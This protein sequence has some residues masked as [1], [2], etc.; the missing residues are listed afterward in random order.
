VDRNPFARD[1]AVN[2]VANLV[3]AAILYLI[4]VCVGLLPTDPTLLISAACVVAFALGIAFWIADGTILRG[5][6]VTPRRLWL[7]SAA[8]VGLGLS[9]FLAAFL[10]FMEWSLFQKVGYVVMG[11]S[12]ASWGAGTAYELTRRLHPRGDGDQQPLD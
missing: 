5:R 12:V 4:G 7:L 8:T 1:V 11:V 6:E 3:A 2:V 9:S 10:P